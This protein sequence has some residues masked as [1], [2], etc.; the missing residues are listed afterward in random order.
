MNP[1]RLVVGIALA[2]TASFLACD[3]DP[4]APATTG[5]LVLRLV[6]ARA[7]SGAVASAPATPPHTLTPADASRTTQELVG[8]DDGAPTR[9]RNSSHPGPTRVV[10]ALAGEPLVRVHVR[11]LRSGTV[12]NQTDLFPAADGSFD[13]EITDLEEG[14]Y[15]VDATGETREA[16]LAYASSNR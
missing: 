11:V 3:K 2:V 5:T 15:T 6:S 10:G 13:G 16:P 7:P 9:P 12:V 4:T 1:Q 14:S 8:A